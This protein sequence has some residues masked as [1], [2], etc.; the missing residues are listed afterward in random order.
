MA[1]QSE[2][3]R[4]AR[5]S[6]QLAPQEHFA[7][8]AEHAGCLITPDFRALQAVRDGRIVG[9]VAYCEWLP[10]SV[11]M[12]VAIENA[13]VVKHLLC[14]AFCYPFEEVGVGLVIAITAS[15]KAIKFCR[16][17]G[18]R[19][20][21]TIKDGCAVGADLI[22]FEMRREECRWLGAKWPGLGAPTL[23]ETR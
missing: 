6:V 14:P 10:N 22:V 4:K 18:F 17:I 2:A 12:H 16:H 23:A 20:V 9:M 1:L 19:E 5:V 15:P 3:V 7:W 8:I 11:R 21:H 13:W